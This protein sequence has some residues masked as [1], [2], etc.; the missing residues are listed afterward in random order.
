MSGERAAVTTL[1]F[2]N[3]A[4]FSSFFARLPAIKNDLGASDGQLGLALFA[5]TVALVVAQPLAGALVHRFG[6][7][8][9]ALAGAVGYGAGLPVAALAPSVGL[10]ALTLFALSFSNG[11]LDVAINVEGV[12]VERRLGRRVLS[13]MHAAFSFGAMT[14]AGGGALAAAVGMEPEP[15]L[16]VAAVATLAVAFV[17]GR[18]LTPDPPPAAGGLAFA[19][20][21]MAL[22]ALG[23]AAFCVLLAEGSVTDWSAV[24][25]SDE[26]GAGEAIAAMGLAVFSLVMAIGRLGGDGLA[27]RFG[28]R[29]VVRCGGAA[30]RDRT[31]SGAGHRSSGAQH[32]RVRADGGGAIGNLPADRG[33][34]GAHRG[35]GGGTGHR[36]GVGAGL[37]GADGGA[38]HDRDPVRRHWPTVGPGARGGSLPAGGRPCGAA[39]P[40]LAPASP[41]RDLRVWGSITHTSRRPRGSRRRASIASMHAKLYGIPGSHPVRTAQLMLDHKGIAWDQVDV[42][43]VLCRPFLRAR[44][45]P[46]P[47]VPALVLDGRTVQTTVAISRML[48]A[49][50]PDPPLFPADPERRSAVEEAERWGNEVLQPVPRRIAGATVVRDRSG[51]ASFLERPLLGMSP[52][53][54][55]ATAGPIMAV[56]RR[57]NHAGD[58]TVRAD[59]AGLPSLLDHVDELLATG[60]IGGEELNAAD[61]QIATTVRLLL[62]FEDVAPAVEGR[63]AAEYARRVVPHYSGHMPNVLPPAWL[64]PLR[65]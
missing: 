6:A 49:V 52:R 59:I 23:A 63:P 17:A 22:L 61:F 14:G 60:T 8:G 5:A 41:A 18:A 27:E 19:R 29:T 53:M 46:G 62:L 55:A 40:P 15:H 33:R 58:E 7:R 31:G 2:V 56:S 65:A 34:R 51:I 36:R 42:P 13:S 16:A 3:G 35:P 48:D 4:I 11:V 39:R 64:A 25:L 47:T 30:R 43:N 32:P 28:A 57:I 54:V 21:S 24:F 26:A 44:G 9:P 12:A 10:L 45:F 37:R 50:R 20:P 1:F 38:G